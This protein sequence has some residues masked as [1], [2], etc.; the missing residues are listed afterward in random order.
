MT[1]TSIIAR[2]DR[3]LVPRG[4]T[5]KK[6]TWNRAHGP[7][8]EVV[9]V[10]T[11]KSGDTVTMNV[12]VL[13]KPIYVACWGHD[14]KQFAEEPECTVRARVGQLIDNKDRWWDVGSTSAGDEMVECLLDR[15]LPFLERMQS[16]EEMR[17]WLAFTGAPSSKYPPPAIYFALLQSQLGDLD[18]ACTTLT[19]LE[20]RALGAWKGAAQEIAA[21]IGC[22]SV[23]VP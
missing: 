23:Q 16:S 18:G 22:A 6:T 11:S 17:D 15:V 7:L 21:R 8:V 20:R 1:R 4:F 10:Q 9:D 19:E 5:R 12:G 3:E 2:L 14:A 13:S